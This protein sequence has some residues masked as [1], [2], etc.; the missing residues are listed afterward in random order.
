MGANPAVAHPVGFQHFLKAKERNNTKL[1]V[2]EPRF[3]KTAA[4]ADMFV[5]LRSGTDIAFVYG[6]IHLILKNGWEDKK[7]LED[8]VFGYEEVFKEAAKWTP[9]VVSKVTGVSQ[10][11]L[12]EVTRV[13]AT[14]KPGCLVWTMGWTQ[15][16]IG[17]SN[18]R[19]GPILQM[20][21]GNMGVEGGGCNILRGHDN[22]QG[23]SDMG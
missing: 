17:T 23:A 4:K 20:I 22:V 21:L 16:S 2:V 13:F 11:D 10:E 7:Y 15:H 1:I 5:R 6:M 3:T 9:D 14:S 8:R 12:L 18:T 19:I